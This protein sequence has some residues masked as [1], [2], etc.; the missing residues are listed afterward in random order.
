MWREIPDVGSASDVAR[1][2]RRGN[3]KRKE[4]GTQKRDKTDDDRRGE[5]RRGAEER[6]PNGRRSCTSQVSRRSQRLPH[7]DM[8][9]DERMN[10]QVTPNKI[11]F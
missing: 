6:K 11:R 4:K 1:E 2:S 10:K 5:K 3:R 8:K 7:C 9:Q